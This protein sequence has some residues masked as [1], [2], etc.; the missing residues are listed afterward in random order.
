MKTSEIITEDQEKAA[1]FAKAM[2]NPYRMFIMELLSKQTYCF[3]CDLIDDLPISPSTLV[4]HLK[5]LKDA[6]FIDCEPE[7]NKMK[8]TIN[9]EK[10]EEAH[11]LFRRFLKVKGVKYL[12]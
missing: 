4:Q 7:G 5:V 11:V 6:G 2:G 3:G 12:Y 9:V 8:Y 1:C 10:W